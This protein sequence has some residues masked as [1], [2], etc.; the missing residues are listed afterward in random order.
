MLMQKFYFFSFQPAEITKIFVILALAKDKQSNMADFDSWNM[1][2][3]A[4]R[5]V[6]AGSI[7]DIGSDIRIKECIDGLSRLACG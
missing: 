6:A 1:T 2:D 3:F 5:L 7:L 4:E